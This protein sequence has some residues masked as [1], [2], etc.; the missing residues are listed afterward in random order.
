MSFYLNIIMIL[1]NSPGDPS[2]GYNH[3]HE[4]II[5]IP[6]NKDSAEWQAE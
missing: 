1:A 2:T 5:K 6:S 4:H 3:A